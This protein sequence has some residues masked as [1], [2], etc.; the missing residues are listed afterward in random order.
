MRPILLDGPSA[1]A[2]VDAPGRNADRV[3]R[4]A[5]AYSTA[6]SRARAL[7]NRLF[8]RS[9]KLLDAVIMSSLPPLLT[10]TSCAARPLRSAGVIPLRRYGRPS[11]HRLPLERAITSAGRGTGARLFTGPPVA[12]C[13]VVSTRA[14]RP[15][16][17]D[18][19]LLS[20]TALITTGQNCGR[21][22]LV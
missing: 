21:L 10:E 19:P 18:N 11:R 12:P 6:A 16:H 3:H 5:T 17:A 9:C 20:R 1:L 14:A 2:S 13:G 7:T 15:P 8:L 4:G 22:A